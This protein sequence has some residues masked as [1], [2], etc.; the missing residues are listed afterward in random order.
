M[1]ESPLT[2]CF[3]IFVKGFTAVPQSRSAAA[4]IPAS[5]RIARAKISRSSAKDGSVKIQISVLI[6]AMIMILFSNAPTV[7]DTSVRSVQNQLCVKDGNVKKYAARTVRMVS[8]QWMIMSQLHARNAMIHAAGS[9][10]GLSIKQ[11]AT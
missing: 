7:R 4:V 1:M 3:A 6:V 8:L 10:S 9:A 2:P 11:T 5:V